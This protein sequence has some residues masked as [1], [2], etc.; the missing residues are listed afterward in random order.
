MNEIRQ[1]CR[2]DSYAFFFDIDGTLA[3]LQA[4]PEAVIIPESVIQQLSVL[5]QQVKGALAFVSGRPITQIDQLTAPLQVPA[6]GVHGAEIRS[7]A[8][9]I[10]RVEVDSQ[11]LEA[12]EQQLVQK[13]T[14]IP[15][16]R[17]E[18][19]AL[20]F[21]LHYRQA[22]AA[23][24]PLQT[25]ANTVIKDYPDFTLQAGKC[26]WEIKPRGC[27]K[28]HAIAHLMQTAPFS[29]RIPVFIGD[30]ITDESG[31]QF[32]NQQQGISIKVG[33]GESVATQRLDDVE[34]VYQWL[35]DLTHS[36]LNLSAMRS[37]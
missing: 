4:T 6:A 8:G 25:L 3:K 9:D 18:K 12:I 15:G 35:D 2:P 14:A 23:E 20:A 21:A 5:C 31:F 22:P 19:K 7:L 10:I 13:V 32:V 1:Q 29:G 36:T 30:D 27:D 11:Q 33:E 24:Q 17:I 34:Q 37:L 16:V 28:G 26:V